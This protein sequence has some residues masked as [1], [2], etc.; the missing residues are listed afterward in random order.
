M[1]LQVL[2]Q[3]K[4]VHKP[5]PVH[6]LE[7]VQDMPVHRQVPEL[8]MAKHKPELVPGMTKRNLMALVNMTERCG[9]SMREMRKILQAAQCCNFSEDM[10]CELSVSQTG[11]RLIACSN[12]F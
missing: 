4:Q 1:K 8:D 10:H 9:T 12:R 5:E 2:V 11:H 6:K 7:L 3:H